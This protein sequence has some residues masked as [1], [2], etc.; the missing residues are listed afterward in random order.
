MGVSVVVITGRFRFIGG[1]EVVNSVIG[2]RGGDEQGGGNVPGN[3]DGPG[4]RAGV[5]SGN[6]I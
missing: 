1:E 3:D 5:H 6:L 4:M 2:R